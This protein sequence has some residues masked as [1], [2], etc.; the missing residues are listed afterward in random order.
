MD[1]RIRGLCHC[2]ACTVGSSIGKTMRWMLNRSGGTSDSWHGHLEES[3]RNVQGCE[4]AA[5]T[6][7]GFL[8]AVCR[9]K[10]AIGGNLLHPSTECSTSLAQILASRRPSSRLPAGVLSARH[11]IALRGIRMCGDTDPYRCH[12]VRRPKHAAH[13][14]RYW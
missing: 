5:V 7:K 2:E 12:H 1:G 10:M 14:R 8:T 13:Q 4:F 6:C 3:D 11:A 9:R